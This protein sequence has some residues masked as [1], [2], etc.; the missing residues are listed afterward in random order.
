MPQPINS[1]L[2]HDIA[3]IGAGA[4]GCM[5]AIR[6]RDLTPKVILIEKNPTIGRKILVTGNRRCNLTNIASRED[7][8]ARFDT[9]KHFLKPAFFTFSNQHLQDF[10]TQNG[11]AVKTEGP[12]KVFPVTNSSRSVVTTLENILRQKNVLCR[13]DAHVLSVQKEAGHFTLHLKDSSPI[14]EKRIIIATGGCSYAHTGSTGDGIRFAQELG[15]RTTPPLAALA[16]LTTKESWVKDL[17]GVSLANVQLTFSRGTKKVTF[18]PGEML[19][20]HFGVSGPL[21]LDASRPI[22]KLLQEKPNVML[23]LDL[24]PEIKKQNLEK[25]VREIFSRPGKATVGEFLQAYTPKNAAK[26]FLRWISL[27]PQKL[28]NQVTK[29]ERLAIIATLKELPLT[30]TGCLPLENAMV[31]DGGIAL[32][33]IHS[34]TLGSKIIP[35]LYFAGETIEGRGPSGGYNLQQ[36]FSTGFLAGESAGKS[37]QEG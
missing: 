22:I 29:A 1:S 27:T 36:A 4:A 32:E 15:H 16:P 33:Q 3:I 13:F 7:F 11:L 25:Q 2:I 6:A 14:H 31:T 9:A 34:K 5:A 28:L 30:I 8:L 12:G 23:F 19:F 21:I 17:Q 18:G 20:T 26:I 10:F 35:G 37:A 24:I